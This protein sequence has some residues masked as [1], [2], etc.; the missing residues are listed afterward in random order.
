MSIATLIQE[1]R[2]DNAAWETAQNAHQAVID[3]RRERQRLERMCE[4]ARLTES[5]A[6]TRLT[7]ALTVIR[8]R[9]EGK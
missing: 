2:D 3:A 4:A 5:E 6:L 8:N 7:A 1:L 9:Q